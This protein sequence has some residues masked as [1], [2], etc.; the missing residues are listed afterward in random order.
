MNYF[1]K[2]KI[3]VW[4]IVILFI[5]NISTIGSIL[6]NKY[7]QNQT[8]EYTD[9]KDIEIPRKRF[10]GFIRHE[11]DLN[12]S[13]HMNF[14]KYR[15]NY[16]RQARA[17]TLEMKNKR[18]ELVSELYNE[19]SDTIKLNKL[20]NKIGILHSDLKKLT[21][22]YYLDMKKDCNEE[23]RERLYDIFRAIQRPEIHMKSRIKKRKHRRMQ[24][25][26]DF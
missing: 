9:N 3:L 21:S 19:N 22:K 17:I 13:Q 15:K 18:H 7:Q 10:G 12:D 5:S 8:I 1:T 16:N 26:M 4:L 2:N 11:L 14:R 23:Q 20:A 6:Y 24:K 25:R